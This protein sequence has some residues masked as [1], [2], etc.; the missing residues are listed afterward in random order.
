MGKWDTPTGARAV[1]EFSVFCES[2]PLVGHEQSYPR[3]LEIARTLLSSIASQGRSRNEDLYMS[4]FSWKL[5]GTGR[6]DI[7]GK[8]TSFLGESV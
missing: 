1:M 3:V 4:L 5:H 2:Y 6:R 7:G 8:T